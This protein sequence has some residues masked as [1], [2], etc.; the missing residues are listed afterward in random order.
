MR[1]LLKRTF[2]GAEYTI[3]HLYYEY[4][5]QMVYFC[6]T[7]E[8]IDRGLKKTQSEA[9]I[10]SRKV[11]GKTAIPRGTYAITLKVQSPKFRTRYWAK[12][13]DGYLPTILGVPCFSRVLIHVGN[14]VNDTQ[15]CVLVGNNRLKGKVLD[16]ALT[17]ERLY[18]KL[19]AADDRGE[20]LSITIQ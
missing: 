12:F 13:C 14:T 7:L 5:G 15:A 3:G 8:P 20:N 19:K 10:R 4:N 17:F 1:L 2:K 16:S 18:K 11:D 6:D 9:V